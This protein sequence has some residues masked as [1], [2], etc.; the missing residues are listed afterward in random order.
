MTEIIGRCVGEATPTAVTFISKKV[1]KVGDFVILEYEGKK[2]LGMIQV[3]MRGSLSI[4]DNI[5]DP[6]VVERIKELEGEDFYIRGKIKILGEIDSLKI[7]RTP[8]PPGTEV[9]LA[10]A[11]ELGKVFGNRESGIR[12]GTLLT[13][14]DVPVYLDLNKLVSRH[15]AILAITGYG[16]SNAV[17]VIAKEMMRFGGSVLIFDMHSEYTNLRFEE[18]SLNLIPTKIN[19]LKLSLQ[20][21]AILADINP[22]QAYVQYRFLSMAHKRAKEDLE[23]GKITTDRFLE[24]IC[25]YLD[26]FLTNEEYKKKYKD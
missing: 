8:A 21:L 25:E 1:P 22:A 3:L 2:V 13:R 9:K 6:S 18:G 4:P 24:R 15:L 14:N 19:P 23:A 20:E 12:I 17:A 10:S 11:E 26:E 7:P 5:F 16:K